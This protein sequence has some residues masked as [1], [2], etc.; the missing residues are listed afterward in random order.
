MVGRVLGKSGHGR[1]T[2]RNPGEDFLI[3]V[4]YWVMPENGDRE[5]DG[6][7]AHECVEECEEVDHAAPDARFCSI[8]ARTR[9]I[10]FVVMLA[11]A[12]SRAT[13]FP[14]FTAK[15]PNLVAAIFLESRKSSTEESRVDLVFMQMGIWEVSY[16]RKRFIHDA[17]SVS[18]C[19]VKRHNGT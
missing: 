10:V 2:W 1:M 14:S 12:R 15:S 17:S 9:S 7:D 4:N 11:P 3:Y 18:L 16:I 6:C 13:S 19:A 8:K 5:T